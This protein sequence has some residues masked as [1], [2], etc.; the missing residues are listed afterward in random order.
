MPRRPL[1]CRTCSELL[2]QLER[3]A[4]AVYRGEAPCLQVRERA[5]DG[6]LRRPFD[7]RSQYL[8][9]KERAHEHLEGH[10]PSRKAAPLSPVG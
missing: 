6:G 3:T 5:M 9:I 7:L 4:D 1:F 10:V 8:T 2:D